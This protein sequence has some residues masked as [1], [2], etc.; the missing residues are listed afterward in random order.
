MNDLDRGDNSVRLNCALRTRQIA[1]TPASDFQNDFYLSRS[2]RT[3]AGIDSPTVIDG[4]V[5]VPTPSITVGLFDSTGS[6]LRL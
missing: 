5:A 1:P 2:V 3:R 6:G 4:V